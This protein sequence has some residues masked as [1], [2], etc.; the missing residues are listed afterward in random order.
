LV[1]AAALG[2]SG[3]V[4]RLTTLMPGSLRSIPVVAVGLVG[5]LSLVAA[6]RLLPDRTIRPYWGRA[7]EILESL[8]AVA[9]VPLGLAAIGLLTLARQLGS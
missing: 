7:A 3:V 6:A 8:L 5:T 1:S 9:L 2:L 4:L